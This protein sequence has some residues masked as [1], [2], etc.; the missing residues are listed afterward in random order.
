MAV[1]RKD[2]ELDLSTCRKKVAERN[3]RKLES[4]RNMCPRSLTRH[5]S[6]W[7]VS[8]HLYQNITYRPRDHVSLDRYGG[9][10]IESPCGGRRPTTIT[11]YRIN[12]VRGHIWVLYGTGKTSSATSSQAGKVSLR[13]ATSSQFGFQASRILGFCARSE[14][15]QRRSHQIMSATRG[16]DMPGSRTHAAKCM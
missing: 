4:C 14:I 10:S 12:N 9:V 1:N 15:S 5:D 7:L 3:P 13:S 6:T 16:M 8:T 2:L 11:I